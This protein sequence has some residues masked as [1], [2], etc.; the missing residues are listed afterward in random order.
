MEVNFEHFSWACL[1]I[2]L[3]S[4]VTLVRFSLKSLRPRNYP[5]G[6]P[7]L[8]FI[9][10]VHHFATPKP[11][12]KFAEWRSKYGDII[13]LKT[14]P[15]NLVVLNSA[16]L[17]RDLL[18]KRGSIY[19]GRPNDYIV[20]NHIVFGAQ[21]ILFLPYDSYLK[22]WR[23]AVVRHLLGPTGVEQVLPVLEAMAAHLTYRLA[24]DPGRFADHFRNWALATPLLAI[25]G[26]RGEQK[27]AALVDLFYGNQENWLTLLTPGMAPPVD[28]FP[29]LK[30]VP[31]FLAKWKRT[32]RDLHRNQ[33]GFYGLMLDSAKEERR[34]K[35]AASI[36]SQEKPPKY[37][38]LMAR[39]LRTQEESGKTEFDDYKLKYLGG[40]LLDAAVDTTYATALA[41]V[42]VLAARPEIMKKARAEVE[43]DI[44]KLPYLR[45][46]YSEILRWRPPAPNNLPHVLDA[47]D[48]VGG[49]HLPK[50]T[51]V[52]QNTWAIERDPELYYDPD[53]F[54]PERYLVNAYGVKP[55]VEAQCRAEGRKPNYAFGSGR[56]QCPGDLFAASSTLMVA[57]KLVWGFELVPPRDGQPL[58][59]SVESGFHGGLVLGSEEFGVEFVP[60]SEGRRRAMM[61]DYERTRG[62]LQ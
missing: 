34:Q 54:D 1:S 20:R 48:T 50:G 27:E 25:C 17:V 52:L 57:A 62:R 41:F 49:Y 18:D 47:D 51:V 43:S 16:R 3:A 29:V 10:N 21:H 33:L 14:G 26:H 42:K 45:A 31:A 13:G 23:T 19:S 56:R 46:C 55:S 36:P 38:S 5:P 40:G 7:A 35:N 2:F 11:F 6:P 44:N 22:Q 30:W 15:G 58:D 4:L 32:A 61:E 59:L 39:I 53:A 8:P 28:M 9:G 37:E 12:L 60:R 24:A